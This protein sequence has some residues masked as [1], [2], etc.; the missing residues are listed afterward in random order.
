MCGAFALLLNVVL[1]GEGVVECVV[2]LVG[3]GVGAGVDCA[4]CAMVS[5]ATWSGIQRGFPNS[6]N[7]LRTLARP[8][9][10]PVSPG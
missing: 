8:S 1:E 2:V 6:K 5:P 10:T 4:R 7:P 3:A 9:A